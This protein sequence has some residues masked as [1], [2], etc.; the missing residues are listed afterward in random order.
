[1]GVKKCS[2][3]CG[4]CINVKGVEVAEKLREKIEDINIK[5]MT[6]NVFFIQ[7]MNQS[8]NYLAVIFVYASTTLDGMNVVSVMDAR[9]A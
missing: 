7:I 8:K 2:P 5:C 3:F 1:M 9:L 4:G 6:Q